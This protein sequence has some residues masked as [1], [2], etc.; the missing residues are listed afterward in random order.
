LP[1]LLLL[2]SLLL[3]LLLLPAAALPAHL[4]HQIFYCD[5]TPAQIWSGISAIPVSTSIKG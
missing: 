4:C 3:L 1:L 2:L 5:M